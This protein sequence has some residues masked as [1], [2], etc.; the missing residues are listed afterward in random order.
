MTHFFQSETDA[1]SSCID[2]NRCDCPKI[3]DALGDVFGMVLLL[4]FPK[5][6]KSSIIAINTKNAKI[7]SAQIVNTQK[8]SRRGHGQE[9]ATYV[10]TARVILLVG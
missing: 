10:H 1:I 8:A 2:A 6:E 7:P 3:L 9:G 5:L 4:G